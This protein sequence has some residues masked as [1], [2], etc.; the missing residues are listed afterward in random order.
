M[1]FEELK[2]EFIDLKD[3]PEKMESFLSE[4]EA[5][6]SLFEAS[7][8]K[9]AEQAEKIEAD[10]KTIQDMSNDKIL[11]SLTKES[12]TAV[13]EQEE[14]EADPKKEFQKLFKE[15]YYN[16]KEEVNNNGSN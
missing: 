4:V 13:E 8:K 5:D 6:Y 10:K 16:E 3:N 1:T 15:R 12:G 7:K 11:A 9:I 2:K 14:T